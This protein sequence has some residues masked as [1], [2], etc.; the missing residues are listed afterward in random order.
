MPL[1]MRLP[2]YDFRFL[3]S[4]KYKYF[5]YGHSQGTMTLSIK[6]FS[7]TTLSIMLVLSAN[8]LT[9]IKSSV[10]V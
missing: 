6:T 7:I 9:V 8:V 2:I 1:F 3:K 10:I 4:I 5:K